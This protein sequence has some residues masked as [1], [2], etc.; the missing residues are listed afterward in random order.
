MV[1]S[2][3]TKA[4][5][6]LAAVSLTF[7][8]Q[9]REENLQDVPVAITAV[10]VEQLDA[11]AI[12]ELPTLRDIQSIAF[13]QPGESFTVRGLNSRVSLRNPIPN[14]TLID[15][16]RLSDMS[17]PD[18]ERIEVL[19]GPQGT[20]YGRQDLPIKVGRNRDG[21]DLTNFTIPMDTAPG[22]IVL[23]FVPVG[24]NPYIHEANVY[25]FLNAWLDQDDLYS[26]QRAQ[27]GYELAFGQGP[28]RITITIN[29]AGPISYD[30]NGQPQQIRIDDRGNASVK[31]YIR[32]LQ[33]SPTGIPFAITPTFSNLALRKR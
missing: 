26:G 1:R 18:L 4:L 23:E 8:A 20:L 22:P 14:D 32:A 24:G 7:S 30:K 19:R 21:V 13:A 29:T 9:A 10:N 2:R 6:C 27:F 12:D 25:A 3:V 17:I 28:G 11:S 31:G 16:V 15:G 5:A 33:G